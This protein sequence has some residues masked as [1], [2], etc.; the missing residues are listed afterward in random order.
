MQMEKP[1]KFS[2]DGVDTIKL[3]VSREYGRALFVKSIVIA[4][5]EHLITPELPLLPG[6]TL[7]LK[8]GR[9]GPTP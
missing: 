6:A 3:V 2:G 9:K 5:K 4:G 1:N 7:E 8:L